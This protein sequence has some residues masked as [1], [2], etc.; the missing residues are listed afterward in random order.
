MRGKERLENDLGD[1]E[2][3]TVLIVN[4]CST[5]GVS[6]TGIGFGFPGEG[7]TYDTSEDPWGG[8]STLIPV[9]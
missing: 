6:G 9:G 5:D 1:V 3:R 2:Q 4:C 7:V 8:A